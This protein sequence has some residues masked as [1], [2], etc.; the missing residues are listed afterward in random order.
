MPTGTP[1][2][3]HTVTA[4]P[5]LSARVQ[6]LWGERREHGT[7][8]RPAIRS[9]ARS[10]IAIVGAFVLPRGILGMTEAS[11]IRNRGTPRTRAPVRKN[12]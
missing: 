1:M 5:A 7:M 6:M 11:H 3:I 9:A 4:I 10:A 8:G 12:R 2:L